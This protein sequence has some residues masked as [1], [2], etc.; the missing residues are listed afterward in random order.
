MKKRHERLL[1]A[2][3]AARF[4]GI[5]LPTLARLEKRGDLLPYRTPGGHR[6][7]NIEMLEE[8]LENSRCSRSR[9]VE[10]SQ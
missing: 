6:R 9:G 10:K 5:S 1:N 2:K 8:C 3:E 7:Y 4:L